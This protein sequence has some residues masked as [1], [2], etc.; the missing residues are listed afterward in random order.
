MSEWI[1]LSHDGIVAQTSQAI[2]FRFEEN[3]VWISKSLIK[4]YEYNSVTVK[5]WFA[6]EEELEEYEL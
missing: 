4:E 5:Y 3:T 2:L 6:E 1:E